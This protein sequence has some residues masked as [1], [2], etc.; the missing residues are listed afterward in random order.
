MFY[1]ILNIKIT[2]QSFSNF[3]IELRAA[4]GSSVTFDNDCD[5]IFMVIGHRF[6]WNK[7]F[8]IYPTNAER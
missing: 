3:C 6:S 4:G 2:S 7:C 5:V 1:Y 8:I